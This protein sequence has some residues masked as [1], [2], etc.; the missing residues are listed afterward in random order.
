MMPAALSWYLETA[1]MEQWAKH[2]IFKKR[3]SR[4]TV[5]SI[6]NF[7]EVP[8]RTEWWCFLFLQEMESLHPQ[9]RRDGHHHENYSLT[10]GP[11]ESRDLS[12]RKQRKGDFLVTKLLLC[13]F[14][15]SRE[16]KEKVTLKYIFCLQPCMFYRN[17]LLQFPSL[18]HSFSGSQAWIKC[19]STSLWHLHN[20]LITA[21]SL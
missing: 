15:Q 6:S 17:F 16:E 11:Q 20:A 13:S 21:F 9:S 18:P 10:L 19:S 8:W 7:C 3:L 4:W 12:F 2:M 5:N 14:S 1:F